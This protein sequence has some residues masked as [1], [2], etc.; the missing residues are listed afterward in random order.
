MKLSTPFFNRVFLVL[1]LT[2]SII[3]LSMAQETV[4]VN[5]RVNNPISGDLNQFA[6]RTLFEITTNFTAATNVQIVVNIDGLNGE[7]ENLHG[8]NM[9]SSANKLIRLQPGVN[10]FSW[11][12]MLSDFGDRY[13]ID[14]IMYNATSDQERLLVDQRTL[15]A[16]DYIICV[17]VFDPITT[18]E[19]PPSMSTS[20][21]VM[22]NVSLYDPPRIAIPNDPGQI[23]NVPENSDNN[24]YF[25]WNVSTNRPTDFTL[26]IRRF[27]DFN[28]ASSFVQAGKPQDVFDGLELVGQVETPQ[29][30]YNSILDDLIFV[31][32]VFYVCQVVAVSNG[33]NYLNGGRS[34]FPIF[35]YGAPQNNNCQNPSYTANIVFPV[36]N[37]TIPF[38]KI[39]QMIQ[40]D[41]VCDNLM[42][43]NSAFTT[44]SSMGTNYVAIK[45]RN[46]SNSNGPYN[47]L[48]R[49]LLSNDPTNINYWLPNREIAGYLLLDD[50]T[51]SPH[52]YD[53]GATYTTTASLTT[54]HNILSGGTSTNTIQL[55][56]LL[57]DGFTVGMPVPVLRYPEHNITSSPGNIA[58]TFNTGENP[59]QPLP[60]TKLLSITGNS[61][62]IGT[63]G[64][65]E[66]C[67]FQVATTDQFAQGD[68]VY[69]K[70]KKI[71]VEGNNITNSYD[72]NIPTTESW[73][74]GNDFYAG[75][76]YDYRGFMEKVYRDF[77]ISVPL[78]NDGTYYWRVVWLRDPD[79]VNVTQPHTTIDITPSM[80]YHQS[81]TRIINIDQ[82]GDDIHQEICTVTDDLPEEGEEGEE[83]ECVSSAIPPTITNRVAKDDVSVGDVVTI[84]LF[85]VEITEI[86][87]ADDQTY[88]GKGSLPLDFLNGSKVNVSI[89]NIKVN[90]ENQIYLGSVKPIIDQEYELEESVVS[91]GKSL[92]MSEENANLLS[93]GL[94]AGGKLLSVLSGGQKLN[95]PLGIDKEVGGKTFTIALLDFTLSY[96]EPAILTTVL[97]T[98][99]EFLETPN[100]FLSFGAELQFHPEGLASDGKM[101]KA[102]DMEIPLS[103]DN[104]FIVNGRQGQTDPEKAFYV[105][106][107]CKGFKCM[108]VAAKM[109]FS[110]DILL[111]DTE[112]GTPGPG[113]VKF[114]LK[115]KLCS[116]SNFIF[117]LDAPAFQIPGA[118]GWAFAP[119]ED[120][121]VDF[122][123]IANAPGFDTNLPEG[124][125]HSSF[126][127]EDDATST[128]KEEQA[129]TWKG[130]YMGGLEIKA[131][132][133]FITEE[134][135]RLSFGV[136]NLIIDETGVS[137]KFLVEDI[138]DINSGKLDD[139]KFSIDS[140]FMDI[141]QSS[142][143]DAGFSGEFG[144]PYTEK[145]EY[146]KYRAVFEHEED[147]NNFVFT[148]KPKDDLKIPIMM[149][150]AYVKPTTYIE[151]S[152]GDDTFLEVNLD[153]KISMSDENIKPD[154]K[155]DMKSTVSMPGVDI[156]NLLYNSNTGFKNTDAFHYTVASPQKSLGGFPISLKAFRLTP[157]K[158]PTLY[159]EPHIVLI[160]GDE[161][162][163]AA[164][165]G[166]DIVT[167]FESGTI[168]LSSVELRKVGLNVLTNGVKLEGEIE[169]YND[170]GAEG[171]RG[172]VKL[173]LKLGESTLGARIN[174][175]FGTYKTPGIE[176]PTYDTEDWYSYF[177]VDGMLYTSEGLQLFAGLSLYGLGGGYY[178]NMRLDSDLPKGADLIAN[179]GGGK[180]RKGEP[181]GVEYK[182]EFGSIGLKFMTVLG[183]N[184][185][186]GKS[187][188]IDAALNAE[189]SGAGGLTELGFKGSFRVMDGE[190]SGTKIGSTATAP[191]AG[192]LRMTYHAPPEGEESFDGVLL[193]KVNIADGTLKGIGGDM[194]FPSPEDAG[195]S[196]ENAM[197]WA[198]FY[199]GP[200][201]WFYHMGRPE[202]HLRGGLSLN[203][204]G[205]ETELVRL[206]SYLM[207]G[208]DIPDVLPEPSAEFMRIFNSGNPDQQFDST[209]GSVDGL[210]AGQPRVVP[211]PGRGFAFGSSLSVNLDLRA[212]PFYARFAMAMGFDINVT[213]DDD[214]VCAESGLNPG[215]NKWYGQGQFYA[216]IEG[217]IG[218]Y[219]DLWFIEGEFSILKAMAAMLLKG[220]APN[221]VWASG[222]GRINY[223]ILGGLFEGSHTFY[224]EIGEK[225]TAIGGDPLAG[226]EFIQDIS[227]KGSASVF[228]RPE[229]AYSLSMKKVLEI[230]YEDDESFSKPPRRIKPVIHLFECKDS[231]GNK[232]KGRQSLSEDGYVSTI[233][234]TAI[235]APLEEHTITVEVKA[236]ELFTD[237]SERYMK[238]DGRDWIE[239]KT[240]NFT[241][242]EAPDVLTTEN[243]AAC[244]P[245]EKQN[246]FLKG[247]TH[248]N[249]GFIKLAIGRPD[250][251]SGQSNV[252]GYVSSGSVKYYAR[253]FEESGGDTIQVPLQIMNNHRN[254]WFNVS[255]LANDKLY[256]MQIV[257]ENPKSFNQLVGDNEDVLDL[258]DII[259]GYA[260]LQLT[261]LDLSINESTI[262]SQ[263]IKQVTLPDNA[264]NPRE[265]I[266]Y[267]Y[268][269]HTSKYDLFSEK[270]AETPDSE[271]KTLGLIDYFQLSHSNDE[272]YEFADGNSYT[273]TLGDHIA[274]R[275]FDAMI[276]FDIQERS[277]SAEF[278]AN[279]F[280][281]SSRNSYIDRKVSRYIWN[282]RSQMTNV[283]NGA[284][285]KF[286]GGILDFN[287]YQPARALDYDKT[288]GFTNDAYFAPRL[289]DISIESAF[290]FVINKSQST[291]GAGNSTNPYMSL[292]NKGGKSGK[293]GTANNGSADKGG[294]SKPPSFMSGFVLPPL[295]LEANIG[296]NP[297]LFG[298][299]ELDVFRTKVLA[300]LNQELSSGILSVGTMRENLQQNDPAR[301][302]I[303]NRFLAYN[304][305]TT[306]K[307]NRGTHSF[308]MYY[309]YPH[310]DGTTKRG[311]GKEVK[312]QY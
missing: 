299:V 244:Y 224:A 227:P 225:C 197:V 185:D 237:G 59:R 276:E 293:G 251:L 243:I 17:E 186:K 278:G 191:V 2:V 69:S 182:P 289:S 223:S 196:T 43:A 214:R 305:A 156:N 307:L 164:K 31:P 245:L 209:Q 247:E 54:E 167:S 166:I 274:Q 114:D 163:L 221:P 51:D 230:P 97:N 205:T 42:K 24:V 288:V 180:D 120:L 286:L 110:R 219:V 173:D 44:T 143:A 311:S 52:L 154:K 192:Y 212:M 162:G 304:P 133:D 308:I 15:P 236:K 56:E 264:L 79:A 149:A 178:R 151:I 28:Q 35:I 295:V 122:S 11:A 83:S 174:A 257:K 123:D 160:D 146:L 48:R 270:L 64:V 134:G 204:P 138:L 132:K 98:D 41:P 84:G 172:E 40:L 206:T 86:T 118:E 240:Q 234:P 63:M 4:D 199:V 283:S 273:C 226:I 312:W 187:Y 32:G 101:Y 104:Y 94:H 284:K 300:F 37:D 188:N 70:L 250:L 231:D 139:C 66:K 5:V 119:A 102:T 222:K 215:V 148:V 150:T 67:V 7:A 287:R 159:L 155:G 105:Q 121:Y 147:N 103:N 256:G 249:Q 280:P 13:T 10:S 254:L 233:V 171:I 140:I 198:T 18:L 203:L 12:N 45:E 72:P 267:T 211:T 141:V 90:Q 130:F 301:L 272:P 26:V 238:D 298:Y 177:Y 262:T 124:Y 145:D 229:A 106:W 309:N 3:C 131:P 302:Q 58:F 303:C 310:P 9:L 82:N 25:H 55:S 242:T 152:L 165:A 265:E 117:G 61:A 80:I 279:Y 88:S 73:Q 116:E 125:Q 220:G 95:L 297:G 258:D 260:G 21:C 71:Q 77:D 89:N 38:R 96:D 210:M 75:R 93:A 115:A 100:S 33:I 176:E 252:P 291:K 200:D 268:Y 217:D 181:S 266:L 68:I 218:L 109:K 34:N 27:A 158:E 112:D 113:N 50:L 19:Y 78:T 126:D 179:D 20:N 195:Q 292:G 213:Q 92:G 39:P 170:S 142:F 290:T 189:F 137:L 261:D 29:R 53:R 108:N 228:S 153:A 111:P 87:Q 99:L 193:L 269:F 57:I 184:G 282:N 239:R 65:I 255:Q 47:F 208:Y 194:E 271:K 190:I 16:G 36:P 60:P 168:E 14:D 207:F 74:G 169:F 135:D 232:I 49:H 22:F 175:D 81:G 248:R 76:E 30:D 85:S 285:P 129:N 201:K 8:D 202:P 259:S 241:T 216:G 107:D 128:E 281:G 157:G 136:D 144:I 91:S 246:F 306:M 277:S 235:L 6:S 46:W 23:V 62:V 275:E 253:F 263:E 127:Y 294:G 296:Y 183:S 161:D 1:I